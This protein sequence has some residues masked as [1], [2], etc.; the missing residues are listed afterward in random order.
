M[1]LFGAGE[2]KL[3]ITIVKRF[4]SLST[5]LQLLLKSS[6]FVICQV[7]SADAKRLC[8]G[9]KNFNFV[10]CLSDF[11]L[12]LVKNSFLDTVSIFFFLLC[13]RICH[14]KSEYGLRKIDWELSH[15]KHIRIN[16]NTYLECQYTRTVFTLNTSINFYI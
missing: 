9:S 5:L 11:T 6:F 12:N 15:K 14:L 2:N 7:G 1:L 16:F 3:D 10:S 13:I 8:F 4:L